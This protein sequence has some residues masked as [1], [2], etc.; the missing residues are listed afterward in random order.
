MWV[1]CPIKEKDMIWVYV[2]VLFLGNGFQVH[3]PNVVFTKEDIC[4][5]YRQFDMLRLYTT[6]PNDKAKVVSQCIALPSG[7]DSSTIDEGTKMRKDKK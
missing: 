1:N 4:Q 2:V 3:A 5:K 7:L 6:K